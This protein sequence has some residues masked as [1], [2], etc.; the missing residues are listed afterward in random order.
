[1]EKKTRKVE[2]PCCASV[3]TS[4]ACFLVPLPQVTLQSAHSPHSAYLP[5]HP[6]QSAGEKIEINMINMIHRCQNPTD[7]I[8]SHAFSGV[9]L[10]YTLIFHMPPPQTS[11]ISQ[12]LQV[13]I[14]GTGLLVA[15]LRLLCWDMLGMLHCYILFQDEFL[16]V[17][18]NIEYKCEF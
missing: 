6:Q 5:Q 13:T 3:S 15:L 18:N 1:M 2:P 17:R 14:H 4:R 8:E 9:L 7:S 12:H 10:E 11:Q 16:S